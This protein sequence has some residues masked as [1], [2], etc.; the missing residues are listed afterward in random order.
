V[1]PSPPSRTI[2][3]TQSIKLV[4]S[5]SDI[6]WRRLL[7]EAASSKGLHKWMAKRSWL[8][9]GAENEWSTRGNSLVEEVDG[10]LAGEIGQKS[11]LNWE[12]LVDAIKI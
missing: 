7:F 6:D 10:F 2:S 12:I 1:E 4:L 9:H 8:L 11:G 3:L 5:A